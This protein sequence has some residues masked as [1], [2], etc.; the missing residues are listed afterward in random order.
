MGKESKAR[1]PV[2]KPEREPVRRGGAFRMLA[3][4]LGLRPSEYNDM[5]RVPQDRK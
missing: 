4:A 3:S 2:V 5:E 1:P